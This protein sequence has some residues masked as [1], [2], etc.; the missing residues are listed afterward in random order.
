M[1]RYRLTLEYD[2]T[3]YRGWQTQQNARS[4]QGTVREAARTLLG[5]AVDLQGAGRTDAGVH[6]L[7]QV[8][9]LD[10]PV[11]MPVRKLQEGLNDLLPAGIHVLRVEDA[12]PDFHARHHARAR[13]YVYLISRRRTAFGKRYVWWVRDR[14][15]VKAMQSAARDIAGFH[16]FASFADRRLEKGRSTR[17]QVER[18]ELFE[19]GELIVFRIAGSHFLWK[20]VRRLVGT[21]VEIGRGSLPPRELKTLL[22]RVSEAPA[23]WTAPPSGLYLEQV[24]YE[25]DVWSPEPFAPLPLWGPIGARDRS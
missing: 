22:D 21:L 8:A 23:A 11:R 13:S 3:G 1:T 9:H 16:D 6:A 19:R 5:A 25:G 4:V 24:L 20:M 7:G 15:D 14:L 12:P 2:G 10:A 18:A 17:V